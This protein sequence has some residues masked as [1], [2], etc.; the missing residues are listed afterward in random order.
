M[1]ALRLCLFHTLLILDHIEN[2]TR[3]CFKKF[4]ANK[5]CLQIFFEKWICKLFCNQTYFKFVCTFNLGYA[6]VYHWELSL[7]FLFG[8]VLYLALEVIILQK[9]HIPI[10]KGNT[11][12]TE[13]RLGQV[14]GWCSLLHSKLKMTKLKFSY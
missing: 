8:L 10:K 4:Q 14:A 9:N 6:A 12:C 11:T 3:W 5:M 13:A 1:W 7:Y 2:L